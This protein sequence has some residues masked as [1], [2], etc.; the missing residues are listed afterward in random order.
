LRGPVDKEIDVKCRSFVLGA[1]ALAAAH[2]ALVACRGREGAAVGVAPTPA[3]VETPAPAATDPQ[4]LV[5]RWL[6]A[7]SNYVIEVASVSAGGALAVTYQ[8]P[9]P[10]NVSRAEWIAEGDR[11]LLAVE[12][13][14]ANYPGNF[15]TLTYDPGSD[16]LVGLYHHLGV[17]ET[18]EVAFSRVTN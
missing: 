5:G 11:L 2:A 1:F 4:N 15:Y 8:N 3:A 9:Q 12:L 6:R 18:Y 7:D 10:I 14:D 17:G 16:S 13:T